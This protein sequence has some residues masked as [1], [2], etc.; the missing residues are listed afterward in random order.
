MQLICDKRRKLASMKCDRAKETTL[1]L[2]GD[3]KGRLKL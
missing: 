3:S 2:A 1:R